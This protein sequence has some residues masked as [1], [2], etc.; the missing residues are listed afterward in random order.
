MS[1]NH[2]GHVPYVTESTNSLSTAGAGQTLTI[3]GFGLS[4]ATTVSIP[5][6]FGVETSR[7]YTKASATSGTLTITMTVAAIPSTPV[8]RSIGISQGGVPCQGPA[9]TAGAISVWHGWTP[10]ALCTGTKDYFW[11][12][13]SI[14]G[15]SDGDSMSSFTDSVQGY[16]L[17]ENTAADQPTYQSSYTFG[18]ESAPAVVSEDGQ[19]FMENIIPLELT[20]G[21]LDM[22]IAFV[23]KMTSKVPTASYQVRNQI[24][25][26]T[27]GAFTKRFGVEIRRKYVRLLT[28]NNYA[29]YGDGSGG[30]IL[31][32]PRLVFVIMTASGGTATLEA[33]PGLMPT[34]L[35]DTYTPTTAPDFASRLFH[36]DSVTGPT[37]FG[38]TIVLSRAITA[39]EIAQLQA[40]WAETYGS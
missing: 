24:G 29:D 30:N 36:G 2:A 34:A 39:S 6:A 33:M 16:T 13:T 12:P 9:V 14:T 40:H 7:S 19:G 31:S 10:A 37:A 20:S 38:E 25:F 23:V 21:V 15:L 1:H 27:A 28:P 32:V 26:S 3:T 4:L 8:V 22:T 11:D 17:T 35:T 18:T 5:T